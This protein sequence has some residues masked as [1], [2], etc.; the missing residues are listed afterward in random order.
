MLHGTVRLFINT[1]GALM[2]GLLLL[3]VA[4]VWR[5][6]QGPVALDFLTPYIEDALAARDGTYAVKLDA[7]VLT[8]VGG[9]RALDVRALGVKV[10]DADGGLIAA[11]PEMSF[12]LAVRPLF[13]GVVAPR[14]IELI[15]LSLHL[16]RATDGRISIGIDN[17]EN[18]DAV[19]ASRSGLIVAA[20]FQELASP[21]DLTRPTGYLSRLKVA[22]ASVTVEDLRFGA[23]W[24]AREANLEARRNRDGI[25]IE[26]GLHIEFDEETAAVSLL[27]NYRTQGREL[28]LST[29]F[30]DVR[31][32]NFARIVPAAADLAAVDVG[33][34]GVVRATGSLDDG[35]R[36]VNFNLVGR[37]GEITTPDPIAN[38]YKIA[39]LLLHGRLADGFTRLELDT[40]ELDFGGPKL[41]V[42]GLVEGLGGAMTAKFDG[43]VQA[44]PVDDLPDYWPKTLA[45]EVR[46]WIKANLS[47]GVVPEVRAQLGV[48]TNA[49][50]QLTHVSIGGG[51][52]LEGFTVKYIHGMTPV[53]GA[54]GKIAF[55]DNSV[56]ITVDDGRVLG[57]RIKAGKLGFVDLDKYEQ[58]ADFDLTIVGPFKDSLQLVDQKPLGF[59]SQLG[60]KAAEASGDAETRLKLRFPLL[61]ALSFKHVKV[62]TKSKLTKVAIPPVL[63][64]LPITEGD[65]DLA[66]DAKG[67][68]VTG[69]AALGAVPMDLAWR[70]NFIDGPFRSRYRLRG[71]LN[72]EGR[73][74]LG[75]DMP[76]FTPAF[77]KGPAASDVT[78]TVQ[79]DGKGE[80]EAKADL[81]E[82][83]LALPGFGW[84][85]P[86]GRAAAA[87]VS[88][89]FG[90]KGI[91][92]VS[93]FA[94]TGQDNLSVQGKVAFASEGGALR[95]VDFTRARFGR[96]DVEGSVNARP[97]GPYEI[98]VRGDGFDAASIIEGDPDEKKQPRG[99]DKKKSDLPAMTI[100]AGVKRV[101]VSKD[102]L[103]ENVTA[104]LQRDRENWTHM[105]VNA[106]VAD[107]KA[108]RV[109]LRSEAKGRS[110]QVSTADAGA[111]LKA[112][113]MFD[114]M[115]G[116]VLELSGAIDDSKPDQPMTGKA[117]VS[118]YRVVN[119]PLLARLLTVAALTGVLDLLTGEGV[120]FAN[121]EAPFVM[122]DG[123][124]FVQDARAYGPALGITAKG[125]VDLDAEKID[126][127]GTVVPAYAINSVLG[128]IP[129]LGRIFTGDKGS[130]ILAFNYVM[131]GPRADPDTRVNPL[132]VL[133]PG[134]LRGLFGIFGDSPPTTPEEARKQDDKKR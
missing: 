32:K 28:S 44:M 77:M 78:V 38:R 104:S 36:E 10:I 17:A 35:V 14:R 133:T 95:Q 102:G 125:V 52:P 33:L 6:S 26:G 103:V 64:D 117:I 110:F 61:K 90:P 46:D 74:K 21:P 118:D 75:L 115:R 58:I 111:M 39:G 108:L 129:L 73:A 122:S 99:R 96:T 41:L 94:V 131:R 47:R 98:S 49:L 124:L 92:E 85:K 16:I 63:L 116:G 51:G 1:L 34:T 62:E 45:P 42:S 109:S 31:P 65:F 127:E 126:M 57:L 132:S 87:D 40:A 59:A 71:A 30:V 3:S 68:D 121:L 25:E 12:S 119:A 69:R 86:V 106:T 43:R 81:T 2:V 48:A 88:A 80:I 113:D 89:R 120:S 105:N 7:T 67:M 15:G 37:E 66:V 100:A 84:K 70:E 54:R 4:T 8:W 60:I 53:T 112:F 18:K 82:T 13:Q 50:G 20:L 130:G 23:T 79:A 91:R 72:D 55:D 76:P 114:N 29:T 101:W 93:R 123:R 134:F 56:T 97:D 19:A 27:G 83:A 11:V 5:L 107:N 128:N 22:R 9:D 24:R